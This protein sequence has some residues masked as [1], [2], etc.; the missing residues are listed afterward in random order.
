MMKQHMKKYTKKLTTMF[1]LSAVSLCAG[2]HHDSF[3]DRYGE[4]FDLS[5][6]ASSSSSEWSESSSSWSESDS[7]SDRG[8][9]KNKNK[10]QNRKGKKEGKGRGRGKK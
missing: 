9:G 10:R 2:S 1:L 3:D 8:R 6:V 7:R 5:E 4:S